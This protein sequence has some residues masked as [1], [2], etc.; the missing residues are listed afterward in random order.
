MDNPSE[1]L[2]VSENYKTDFLRFWKLIPM[3]S[4]DETL[5][6]LKGHLLVEDL[7]RSFCESVVPNPQHL[8][9]LQFSQSLAVARALDDG[10][11]VPDWAWGAASMLNGLRN[12]LAHRLEATEYPKRRAEFMQHV[13]SHDP[14]EG[15]DESFP[16]PH[17]K[18]AVAIFVSYAIMSAHLRHKN[19][20]TG[21]ATSL[22]GSG[23]F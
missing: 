6:V 13:R 10:V 20:F 2:K 4:G 18:L 16:E 12:M 17:Q 15:L 7:L 21:L 1:K 19:H 11:K 22:L 14:M 8:G 9:K 3:R 23:A 5:I